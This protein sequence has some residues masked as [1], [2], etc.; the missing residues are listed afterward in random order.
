MLALF[1]LSPSHPMGFC[2]NRTIP[3]K[4][5]VLLIHRAQCKVLAKA[6]AIIFGVFLTITLKSEFDHC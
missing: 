6:E 5:L 2:R 4:K 3:L 1:A